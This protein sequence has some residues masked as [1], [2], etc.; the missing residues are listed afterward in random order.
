[1]YF[2]K[3]QV[4]QC[5]FSLISTNTKEEELLSILLIYFTKW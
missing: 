3:L 4:E 2:F 1:M 5:R